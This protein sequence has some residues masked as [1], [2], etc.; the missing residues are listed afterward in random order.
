MA[1]Q[2]GKSPAVT[3]AATQLRGTSGPAFTSVAQSVTGDER[4]MMICEAAYYIGEHRGFEAG[5]ELND[6]LLA[7]AQIDA[8]LA[9]VSG[10]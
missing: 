9:G 1:I 5:H 8:A 10:H 6:W 7:E 3:G 2:T 4:R